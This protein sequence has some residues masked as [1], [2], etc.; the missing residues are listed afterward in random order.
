MFGGS[1]ENFIKENHVE[2]AHEGAD[3]IKDD[4]VKREKK[5]NCH[6][7]SLIPPVFM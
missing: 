2:V 7:D 1:Q 4:N 3:A 5:I 6:A